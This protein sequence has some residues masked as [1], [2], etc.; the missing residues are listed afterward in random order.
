MKNIVIFNN[1]LIKENDIFKKVE[2]NGL[3]SMVFMN[4]MDNWLV[5]NKPHDLNDFG[6]M[7]GG[8]LIAMVFQRNNVIIN[9]TDL[10]NDVFDMKF[11]KIVNNMLNNHQFMI[12]LLNLEISNLSILMR[13]LQ[14]TPNH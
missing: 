14:I 13:I 1:K 12:N 11:T 6:Q 7:M 5:L 8:D 9:N 3:N 4:M 10:N 2:G